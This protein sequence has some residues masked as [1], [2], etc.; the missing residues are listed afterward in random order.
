MHCHT[1]GDKRP[2]AKRGLA[3]NGTE[4]KGLAQLGNAADTSTAQAYALYNRLCE[5]M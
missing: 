1:E 3:S 2:A 4:E 5:P